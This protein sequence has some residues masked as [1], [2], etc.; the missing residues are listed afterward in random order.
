MFKTMSIML[1]VSLI[2]SFAAEAHVEDFV[3]SMGNPENSDRSNAVEKDKSG[4]P[5]WNIDAKVP[6]I[7]SPVH[8]NMT[9]ASINLSKVHGRA[10]TLRYDEPYIHGVFW[11][12][13]PENLLCPSCSWVN[14][15]K[16]DKRWG[17]AFATRFKEAERMARPTGDAQPVV[18]K[19]GDGLLERSHFGDLQFLHG[20][21]S[22]DGE[23]ASTTQ[24]KILNWAE[25]SYKIATGEISQRLRLKDLP[26]AEVRSLFRGDP[27]L[28]EKTVEELF[29]GPGF[30]KRVAIG[31]LIHMIQDSYAP[32]HAEREI[33]DAPS[34]DGKLLFKRGRVRE[35]HCYTNQDSAI[36]AEDD[37]WPPGLDS[38]PVGSDDNPISVGAKILSFLYANNGKGAPWEQVESYLETIVFGVIDANVPASPGDRYRR[39]S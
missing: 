2:I 32:G 33:K 30:T 5:L 13:D 37:K 10:Y 7:G 39:R 26:L 21:A 24:K 6:F 28:E 35:F 22:S 27:I 23:L 34:A 9:V 31:T 20:M 25:F 14:L 15:L 17:I 8:E 1:A 29:K 11:N 3:I 16:F 18:F 4:K 38:Y 12:D 36:H 19:N